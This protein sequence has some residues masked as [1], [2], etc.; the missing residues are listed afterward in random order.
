MMVQHNAV[1][2][3]ADVFVNAVVAFST[4]TGLVRTTVDGDKYFSF[5]E[6]LGTQ[7][8]KMPSW[9]R[10]WANFSSF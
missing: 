7:V 9:P 5:E 6:K 8:R 3:G 4:A 10:S 1:T 2:L